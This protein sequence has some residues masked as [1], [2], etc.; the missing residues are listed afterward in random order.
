MLFIDARNFGTLID[1]RHK[2]LSDE[3]VKKISD[4]YHLWRGEKDQKY[5][6]IPGFCKSA[7]LDEIEKHGW[8]LTP[9]RYVGSEEEEIDLNTFEEKMKI[10]TAV[11]AEQM[12]QSEDLD[13]KIKQNLDRTGYGL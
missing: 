5:Q 1:R 7:Y 10:F 6:D 11:L 9:G 12:Q 3:D 13:E 8:I 4:I 2:E